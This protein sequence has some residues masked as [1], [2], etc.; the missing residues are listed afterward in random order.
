MVAIEKEIKGRTL[1]TLSYMFVH[2]ALDKRTPVQARENG[3]KPELLS[4]TKNYLYFVWGL[5]RLKHG[6]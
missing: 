1:V 2:W 4:F 5:L 3:A 6:S